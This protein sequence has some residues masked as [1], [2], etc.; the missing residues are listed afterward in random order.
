MGTRE[1]H[2]S[3]ASC[4]NGYY[5][6]ILGVCTRQD[7]DD[8]CSAGL[9]CKTQGLPID[10][11]DGCA[12]E[13]FYVTSTR[14]SG[15]IK[16][17]ENV[18]TAGYL[19]SCTNS[20]CELIDTP[21]VGYYISA[22]GANNGYYIR[23]E[24]TANDKKCQYIVPTA[25]TAGCSEVGKI[26][27]VINLNGGTYKICYDE[28]DAH[29]IELNNADEKH[30]FT[31]G[32]SNDLGL[33][34]SQNYIVHIDGKNAF[35]QINANKNEYYLQDADDTTNLE[36]SDTAGNLL[37]CTKET[38]VCNDITSKAKVGYYQNA[39]SS[40]LEYIKCSVK[41][42]DVEC[43]PYTV[44]NVTAGQ[45]CT[46]KTIG[47]VIK[48]G[49]VYQLCLGTTSSSGV[50]L[51]DTVKSYFISVGT[52]NVF[53]NKASSYVLV[54][55]ASGNALRDDLNTDIPRYRYTNAD[56]KI[57][58]KNESGM[59]SAQGVPGA[60]IVEFKHE[61]CETEQVQT[62]YYKIVEYSS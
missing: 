28:N 43:K 61:V 55:M 62:N 38:G 41:G 39:G 32:A 21:K 24:K 33:S 16:T 2:C 60:N 4:T 8:E 18:N 51:N 17:V 30:V 12:V 59:C 22:T 34:N 29:G 5:E 47:D 52:S 56:H 20:A 14:T 44:D 10:G 35:V 23:C 13:G 26:G 57:S 6:C 48:D 40:T 37:E 42:S 58:T 7:V 3:D 50:D 53:G 49:G 27:G 54:N 19:Y 31:L 46:G 25:T 9:D 36:T 1:S 11:E 15:S 45:S